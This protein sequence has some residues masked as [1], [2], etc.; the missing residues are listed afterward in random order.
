VLAPLPFAPILAKWALSVFDFVNF[1]LL[2]S[3]LRRKNS[4]NHGNNNLEI[5]EI[6]LSLSYLLFSIPFSA[7]EGQS[8]AL[9]V[10]FLLLP[11]FLRPYNT[12]W[13]YMSIGIGFNWKYVSVL[14]L[15]FFILL[16][17]D[18]LKLLVS[19]ISSM[20][21]TI[22][23]FSFPILFSNYILNYFGYFG[24]LGEYSGQLASN[25]LLLLHP[26]ISSL[27][28]TGV[29]LLAILYWLGVFSND[30]TVTKKIE[31]ILSRS[32]WFPFLLLLGF[33]KIYATAFPWYWMWFYACLSPL[34]QKER[35][36]FTIFL[37]I[38]LF[39]GIFDFISMTI[40]F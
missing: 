7:I 5:P 17:R 14:I 36:L 6:L 25:P 3:L 24:N 33:L 29:L 21:L 30:E 28:S 27:I 39:I 1:F 37:S 20:I 2:L 35:R 12:T 34:P 10:F 8:T 38:T 16:D 13:S 23:L 26:S 22:L 32:Y 18:N 11:L 19:G 9:T 40:G 31:G 4:R 15:P